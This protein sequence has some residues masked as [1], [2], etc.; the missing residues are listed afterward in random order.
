MRRILFLLWMVTGLSADNETS[1][2]M[3]C[4]SSVSYDASNRVMSVTL[5]YID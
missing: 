3:L 5:N 2:V 1:R 4:F